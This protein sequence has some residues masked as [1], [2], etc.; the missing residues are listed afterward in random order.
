ME[1]DNKFDQFEV[2]FE[3]GQ[4]GQVSNYEMW[5]ESHGFDPNRVDHQVIKEHFQ[6]Q[7][8]KTVDYDEQLQE[9]GEF[10]GHF[11]TTGGTVHLPVTGVSG[12]GKTQFKLTV[13][14]AL[15]RVE[16]EF[17][18]QSYTCSD[19]AD[20]VKTGDSDPSVETYTEP[21]LDVVTREM[22]NAENAVF[23]L[24]DCGDDKRVR[25]S[26]TRLES[27]VE[28]ALF[29]TFWNPE[30]WGYDRDGVEREIATTKQI[31]LSGLSETECG[32]LAN[33]VAEFIG[34]DDSPSGGVVGSSFEYSNGVPDLFIRILIKSLKQAFLND[35]R[36]WAPESVHQ[37]ADQL[38][39]TNVAERIE[40]LSQA[41]LQFIRRMLIDGNSRGVQ[42]KR[43]VE[44][45]DRDKST[46]SYHLNDLSS[47]DL[48][49]S[50]TEGRST[51]YSVNKFI[52]PLVQMRLEKEVE[53]NG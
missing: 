41:K 19:L 10:A 30:C 46:V 18:I 12:V 26:M 20:E 23:I 15:D 7:P 14:S 22:E 43:L 48:V 50:V 6:Q 25:S 49:E 38:G 37:A 40:S 2:A 11:A 47:L 39:L 1:E 33:S 8:A 31:K 42:P 52:R 3:S 27:S 5:L 44:L 34:G 51:R 45:L 29:I 36:P 17:E 9:V 4:Q 16:T 21:R 35:Q 24:D 53:I 32:D 28:N 13:E